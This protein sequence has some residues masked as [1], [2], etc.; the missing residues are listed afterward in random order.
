MKLQQEKKQK[1][2]HLLSDV[3]KN[4]SAVGAAVVYGSPSEIYFE[5]TFGTIHATSD[6]KVTLDTLFD[7][8]S[9]TKVVATT[10]LL[11]KYI[12]QGK[13]NLTDPAIKFIPE[14]RGSQKSDITIQD[15]VLHQS[16][17]SDED[18][19]GPYSS[20]NEF[21]DEMFCAPVRFSP[22]TSLEYCDVNY[23]LLGLCLERIG[24]QQLEALC[25]NELWLPLSMTHTHYDISKIIKNK[26]AGQGT[27]WGSVD[28]AQD[29]LL[30]KPLGC[31][32]VFTTSNDLIK[33]CRHSLT[34]LSDSKYLSRFMKISAG[35]TDTQRSFYESLG[36]GKK[37]YG[38]EQHTAKQSYIGARHTPLTIEKAGGAGAF[39]CIRQERN[40]FYIYLT[41]HGRPDPF[42][43]ESWDKLV[44][45]LQTQQ[46]AEAIMK[47]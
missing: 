29:R 47:L 45:N 6:K 12:T 9:I 7:I 25:K 23:R 1:V 42:S 30:A 33:F 22:G 36:L 28:D 35:A 21:W 31:D 17:M 19:S 41:N 15:L 18:F 38:W 16:G 24:N 14:L 13:I 3:F 11:E 39:V 46:I 20:A 2:N 32:G 10:W 27:T 44:T 5:K 8:Q 43:M 26:I 34:K 40:D 4:S 37:A